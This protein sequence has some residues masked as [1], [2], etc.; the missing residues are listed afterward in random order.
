M[1]TTIAPDC[2]ISGYSYGSEGVS[3]TAETYFNGNQA[4]SS[5]EVEPATEGPNLNTLTTGE[6][7]RHD[8]IGRRRFFHEKNRSENL[9]ESATRDLTTASPAW[10]A[11]NFVGITGTFPAMTDSGNFS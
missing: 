4:G 9:W 1:C 11:A 7:R 6:D 10:P 2:A 3:R 8:H 5:R